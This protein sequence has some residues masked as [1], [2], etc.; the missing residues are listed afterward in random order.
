MGGFN[1]SE[2]KIKN[3]RKSLQ[4]YSSKTASDEHVLSAEAAMGQVFDFITQMNI[5][6]AGP[7]LS[8]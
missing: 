8:P 6:L 7:C 5:H 4:N 1:S 2:I 3:C